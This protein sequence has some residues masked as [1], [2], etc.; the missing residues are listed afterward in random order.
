MIGVPFIQS[1]NCI[2]PCLKGG[3]PLNTDFTQ[4]SIL[5]KLSMFMPPVLGALI[6]Q[7]LQ[8]T[9]W[10]S[11]ASSGYGVASKIVNFPMLPFQAH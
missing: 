6:L 10:A 8:S 7:C 3:L 1:K 5:K 4:G 11:Q 9:D 2:R